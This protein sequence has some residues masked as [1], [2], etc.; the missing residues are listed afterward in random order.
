MNRCVTSLKLWVA[1]TAN[2][3]PG[4]QDYAFGM[5]TVARVKAD[6]LGV[7]E[8]L[9]RDYGD[10]VSFLTGPYR[11]HIFFHP[12]QVREVLVTKAKSLIRL[13]RVMDTFAQWNG[14]SLLIVEGRTL[15]TPAAARSAGFSTESSG[16]VRRDHGSSALTECPQSWGKSAVDRGHHDVDSTESMAHLTLSIICRTMFSTEPGGIITQDR[17]GRRH[18]VESGL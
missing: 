12:D 2:T 18:V 8:E 5:R 6:I 11:F 4:P 17:Q 13:P 14:K 9:K 15:D 10:S 1:M 7:Y 3:P 16:K